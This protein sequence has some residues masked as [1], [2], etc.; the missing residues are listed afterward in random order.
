MLHLSMFRAGEELGAVASMRLQ[1]GQPFPTRVCD[2]SV[3]TTTRWARSTAQLAM[4][5][6]GV[7]ARSKQDAPCVCIKSPR[8]THTY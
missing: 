6:S 1:I 3:Q 5:A 4:P 7:P 8:R 2:S